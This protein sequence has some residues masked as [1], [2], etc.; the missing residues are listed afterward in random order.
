M[1]ETWGGTNSFRM[2][3]NSESASLHASDWAREVGFT[4]LVA[5]SRVVAKDK[6]RAR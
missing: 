3:A 4:S 1:T 5:P 2:V 6:L